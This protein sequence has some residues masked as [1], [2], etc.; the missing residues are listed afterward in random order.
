MRMWATG[1]ELV[2]MGLAGSA[3]LAAAPE[4]LSQGA[5]PDKS[6]HFEEPDTMA[7]VLKRLEGRAVKLRLAGSGEELTGKLQKVGKDLV[8]VSDLAGREFYDAVVRI[9]QVSTV[10]VQVR[11]GR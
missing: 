9:D 10:V 1:M 6:V 8:H 4:A 7:A 2:V 11:G 5:A 3:L